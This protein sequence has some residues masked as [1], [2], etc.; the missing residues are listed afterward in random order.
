MPKKLLSIALLF[1]TALAA[2]LAN[3][4]SGDEPPM[5]VAPYGVDAG[6]CQD[7]DNPCGSIG[8]ALSKVG[9]GGEIRV[10]TG[11]YVVNS[12]DDLFFL[13][14]GNVD[15]NGGFALNSFV[16]PA[17]GRST[18]VGVPLSSPRR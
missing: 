1:V 14:N 8:Y 6:K 11:N 3:A 16:Q 9:K 12:P 18:L 7:I 17:A 10:A 15:I 4:H 13:I 5:F 2:G